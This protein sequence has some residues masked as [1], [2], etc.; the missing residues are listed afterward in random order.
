MSELEIVRRFLPIVQTETFARERGVAAIAAY[1]EYM[2][3]HPDVEGACALAALTAVFGP[4]LVSSNEGNF[5]H[6]DAFSEKIL[7]LVANLGLEGHFPESAEEL[8]E[9]MRQ[10]L[11][12]GALIFTKVNPVI[13]TGHLVGIAPY[14]PEGFFGWHHYKVDND[15]SSVLTDFGLSELWRNSF[16]PEKNGLPIHLHPVFS[17]LV[18]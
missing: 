9:L 1:Q 5:G 2:H 14:G 3:A 18:P 4:E 8:L 10:P 7:S 16:R 11:T 13:K 15:Q 6:I 12:L 17:F